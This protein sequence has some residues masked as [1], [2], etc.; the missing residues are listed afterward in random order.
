MMSPRH[1][2]ASAS[3]TLESEVCITIPNFFHVG[4]GT[5]NQVLTRFTDLAVFPETQLLFLRNSG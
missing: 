2:P 3:P 4:S 5:Q 1:P